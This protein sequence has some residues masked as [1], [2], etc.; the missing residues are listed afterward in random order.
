MTV[1]MGVVTV[2]IGVPVRAGLAPEFR[3]RSLRERKLGEGW[4]GSR[5]SQFQEKVKK[6]PCKS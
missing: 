5:G 2:V 3:A 1:G 6:R 4:E